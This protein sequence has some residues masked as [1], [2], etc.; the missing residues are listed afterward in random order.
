MVYPNINQLKESPVFQRNISA[1]AAVVE[2][3]M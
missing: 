3:G 1:A 2:G